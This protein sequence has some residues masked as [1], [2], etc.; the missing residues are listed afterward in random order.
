MSSQR[1][2]VASVPHT[3]AH[4]AKLAVLGYVKMY[5]DAIVRIAAAKT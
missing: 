2:T 5:A 4:V 3:A 1:S